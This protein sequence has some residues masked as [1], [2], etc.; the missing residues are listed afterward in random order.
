[1]AAPAAQGSERKEAIA[2]NARPGK[3]TGARE[4]SGVEKKRKRRWA[5]YLPW[6]ERPQQT[7]SL[8]SSPQLS[9]ALE[10]K[11]ASFSC[12][13]HSTAV[14]AA[15]CSGSRNLGKPHAALEAAAKAARC[16]WATARAT[17]PS[18]KGRRT[19]PRDA[20]GLPGFRSR[21]GLRR[22]RGPRGP[23]PG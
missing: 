12:L 2:E 9:R 3:T 10:L 21:A 23:A 7:D 4:T 16:R 15:R 8:P 18:R 13:S 1:M 17:P 6:K 20:S 22:R 14:C 5:T 19:A 11:L